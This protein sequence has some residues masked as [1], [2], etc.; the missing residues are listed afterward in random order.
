MS[1]F[2]GFTFEPR[3]TL[4]GLMTLAAGVIAF[5]AVILQVR[6]SRRD[7]ERQLREDKEAHAR[8]EEVR[9]QAVARSLLFEVVSFYTY[10]YRYLSPILDGLDTESCLP[11]S[12]SAPS[13]DFFAVYRGNTD[14]LGGFDH[15]LVEKIVR[16]YGRAE[17]LFTSI[18][19]YTWSLDREL[20]RQK[21]VAAGS[22]PRKLLQQI[23]KLMYE[24]DTA[25]VEA[26]KK[27]CEVAGVSFDSLRFNA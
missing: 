10:Y 6:S 3:L 18:R 26:M 12:V 13:S 1:F 7:L 9:K 5:I 11:P 17:W 14:Y 4:D 20:E 22:A 21:N 8:A 27:L 25:A 15:A 2:P 16:F 24:T 19:E 23:Q